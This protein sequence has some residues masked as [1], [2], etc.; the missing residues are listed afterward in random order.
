EIETNESA[1]FDEPVEFRQP[2]ASEQNNDD[3]K[4]VIR[5]KL[6][7]GEERGENDGPKKDRAGEPADK[8][9]CL[10]RWRRDGRGAGLRHF[11]LRF[12]VQVLRRRLLRT[13]IV[14][15][16]SEIVN[17]GFASTRTATQQNHSAF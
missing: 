14:N 12:A 1:L 17:L 10:R 4:N 13:R 2:K 3:E 7:S 9:L 8:D 16:K 5:Q 11:A 6:V 15:R